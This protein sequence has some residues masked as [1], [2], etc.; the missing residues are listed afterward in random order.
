M[1]LEL[2]RKL[3]VMQLGLSAAFVS[4]DQETAGNAI[5]DGPL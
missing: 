3:E 2:G 1:L 5:R 4:L